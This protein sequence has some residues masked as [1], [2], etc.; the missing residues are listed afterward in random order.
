VRERAGESVQSE[1]AV[2]RERESW[3]I[4][5]GGERE[6]RRIGDGREREREAAKR[7]NEQRE[8]V[9]RVAERPREIAGDETTVRQRE[10]PP[11]INNR[12]IEREAVRER[13]RSSPGEN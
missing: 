4:E 13:G 12:E 1:M 10:I 5:D 3:R 2:T 6:S 8:S 11:E 7:C 9:G